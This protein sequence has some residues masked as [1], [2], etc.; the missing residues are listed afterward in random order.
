M[1]REKMQFMIFLLITM[2]PISLC[3]A[4]D[5]RTK[6]VN[7][8]VLFDNSVSMQGNEQE[9]AA[10]LSE[11]VADTILQTGDTLTILSV[12]NAPVEE[13]SGTINGPEDITEVKT[14]L[15]SFT[16]NDSAGNFRGAFENLESKLASNSQSYI[17]LVT[18]MSLQTSFLSS[19]EAMHYLTYSRTQDFPGWKVMIISMDIEQKVKAA[20]AAYMRSQR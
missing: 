10:W 11:H 17:I 12:S 3:F 16:S 6:P 9:A 2:L 15:S 8:Y 5:E 4:E 14:I 1:K 18:G 19:A 13:F 7:V 20:A